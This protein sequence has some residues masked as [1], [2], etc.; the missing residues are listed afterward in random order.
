MRKAD[1]VPLSTAFVTRSVLPATI[2][3]AFNP[4]MNLAVSCV[5]FQYVLLCSVVLND[6]KTFEETSRRHWDSMECE[7]ENEKQ[8][9]LNALID[10]SGE[11]VDLIHESDVRAIY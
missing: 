9:I 7:W 1:S 5:S 8:K 3:L 6:L 10:T 4:P 11:T 2:L